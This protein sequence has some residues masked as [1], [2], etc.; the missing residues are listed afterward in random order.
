MFSKTLSRLQFVEKDFQLP[1]YIYDRTSEQSKKDVNIYGWKYLDDIRVAVNKDGNIYLDA[2]QKP[3]LWEADMVAHPVH[4]IVLK[5]K[6]EMAILSRIS[7]PLENKNCLTDA[8]LELSEISDPANF[9]GAGRVAHIGGKLVQGLS[10]EA[11]ETLI[12]SSLNKSTFYLIRQQAEVALRDF[13]SK[14]WD[15]GNQAILLKEV[16]IKAPPISKDISTGLE[17]NIL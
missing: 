15:L 11:G 10:K 1:N 16:L 12:K 8:D 7:S 5:N 13:K 2:D 9:T 6:I 14:T 17:V 4:T 3:V